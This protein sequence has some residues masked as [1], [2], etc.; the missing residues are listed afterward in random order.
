MT[1]KLDMRLVKFAR[2]LANPDEVSRTV[3]APAGKGINPSQGLFVVEVC[4]MRC[5]SWVSWMVGAVAN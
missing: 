3:V 5:N 4:L 2:A 1:E